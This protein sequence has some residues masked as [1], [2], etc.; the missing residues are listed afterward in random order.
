MAKELIINKTYTESRVALIENGEILDLLIDRSKEGQNMPTV[1]N[2]Y[3]GKVLRVLPGMQSAFVDIGYERA[4]FLYVDDAYIPTVEEQKEMAKRLEER[5]M[6]KF[7][8]G[9]LISNKGKILI[10]IIC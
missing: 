4:A 3:L 9:D 5:E 2:I 7:R 1:G 10:F 6:A 8:K